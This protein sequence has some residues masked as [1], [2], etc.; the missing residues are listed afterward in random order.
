[1]L[2]DGTV[3]ISRAVFDVLPG[4]SRAH[5]RTTFQ[6]FWITLTNR[7]QVFSAHVALSFSMYNFALVFDITIIKN[8][9][10]R[11]CCGFVVNNRRRSEGECRHQLEEVRGQDDYPL[12]PPLSY[13]TSVY[14]TVI[15]CHV[16]RRRRCIYFWVKEKSPLLPPSHNS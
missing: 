11:I 16:M 1:M 5:V 4:Y 7:S 15:K 13:N 2:H 3:L 14:K 12:P 9:M 8:N 10:T 6:N